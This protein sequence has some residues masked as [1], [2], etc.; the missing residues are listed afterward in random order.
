MSAIALT[1]LGKQTAEN[2][3]SGSSP[4]FAVLSMLY[5]TNGPVDFEEICDETRMSEE[6]ASMIVR[7]LIGRDL[8]REV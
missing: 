5:E 2:T 8:V 4:E 6:K 7:R 1:P 3:S